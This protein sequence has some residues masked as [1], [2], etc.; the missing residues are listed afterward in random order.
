MPNPVLLLLILCFPIT[1][2]AQAHRDTLLPLKTVSGSYPFLTRFF[3]ISASNYPVK[4]DF[5]GVPE[6]LDDFRV[7]EYDFNRGQGL[8]EKILREEQL[9]SK[10][11]GDFS[12]VDKARLTKTPHRHS[13]HLLAGFRNADQTKVLMVDEDNNGTFANDRV[14]EYPMNETYN[15]EDAETVLVNYEIFDGERI[16]P[17][18]KLFKVAPLVNRSDLW[19]KLKISPDD[20]SLQLIR[21]GYQAGTL[22][23]GEQTH[24]FALRT[25][26]LEREDNFE[27]YLSPPDEWFPHQPAY[28][29]SYRMND[30][31]YLNKAAYR[32]DGVKTEN[33]NHHLK[34]AFLEEAPEKKLGRVEGTYAYH[35]EALSLEDSSRT[36]SSA[37]R[38]KYILL[39]FW[40]PWCKPCI[41]E[42]PRLR[43]LYRQFSGNERFDMLGVAFPLNGIDFTALNQ[44]LDKHELNWP[45]WVDNGYDEMGPIQRLMIASYPTFLLLDPEGKIVH[46]GGRETFWELEALLEESVGE[47]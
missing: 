2:F 17:V 32:L 22:E 28:E 6:N 33:G 35:F 5:P 25:D 41:D 47:E 9:S 20:F 31:V 27:L 43:A 14:F 24:Y 30:T 42:F 37:L 3:T 38:G 23:L 29:S 44:F 18:C 10:E 15:I 40:G 11:A 34:L 19:A 8:Y 26:F 13:L 7:Y 46:R 4:E 36:F 16:R 45:Q 1:F 12:H 21:D 39:D